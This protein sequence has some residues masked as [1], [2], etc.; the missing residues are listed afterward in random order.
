MADKK[1]SAL[2]NGN[3][4]I[5]TDL[6]PIDRSGANF[7][8]SV[9]S[10][11]NING[12]THPDSPSA[13]DDEFE[14]LVLDPK[15]S[16][17][18]SPSISLAE[19]SVLFTET[20]TNMHNWEMIVQTVPA[21]PY[22]IACK[23]NMSGPV[24]QNYFFAGILVRESSSG[25]LVYWGPSYNSAWILNCAWMT[26]PNTFQGTTV[27]FTALTSVIQLINA[28]MP[29]YFAIRDDGSTRFYEISYDGI[30]WT[31]IAS[32]AHNA[33]FVA[34]QVGIGIDQ[35]TVFTTGVQFDWFRKVA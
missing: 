11:A 32:E 28:Q 29:Q 10:L 13:V 22:R 19:G 2:T 6:I 31:S 12:D 3:P 35:Y 9:G 30:S 18:N 14:N 7:S 23:I 15:W 8:V 4:A 25:K 5:S 1:I 16:L 20:G 21:T 17:I 24:G 33:F 26:D 27:F 34:D